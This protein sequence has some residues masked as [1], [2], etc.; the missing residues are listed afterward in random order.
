MRIPALLIV[1]L[2]VTLGAAAQNKGIELG[3]NPAD[4]PDTSYYKSFRGS[5][6]PRVFLS[7]NYSQLTFK[8]GGGMPDMHYHANTPL[9]FGVGIAYKYFSFSISRGLGF[10]QSESRK[11]P[12]KSFDLQT[13]VYRRKWTFDALA[14]F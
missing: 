14:Q 9:N 2:S 4:T 11:G 10:L 12:T 5:I 8:P 1:W 13:H 3:S 7:R 6:I